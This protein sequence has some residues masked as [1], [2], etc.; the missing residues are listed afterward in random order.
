PAVP[1]AGADARE[2][3]AAAARCTRDTAAARPAAA[4]AAA[5]RGMVHASARGLSRAARA[6]PGERL[7]LRAAIPRCHGGHRAPRL[8]VRPLPA[9]ARPGLLPEWR[10]PADPATPAPPERPAHR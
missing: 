1:H 7:T 5:F 4:C 10:R 8:P 2:V 3:L 6:G 9:R